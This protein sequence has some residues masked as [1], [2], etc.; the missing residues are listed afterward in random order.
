MMPSILASAYDSLQVAVIQMLD[1]LNVGAKDRTLDI[2][3]ALLGVGETCDD[4]SG[5]W[6]EAAPYIVIGSR[7]GE[8]FAFSIR[9]I[10]VATTT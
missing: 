1:H 3:F 10:L 7:H 5:H 4:N 6:P 8:P 2:E 9:A